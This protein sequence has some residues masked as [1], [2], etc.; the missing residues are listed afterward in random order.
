MATTAVNTT[1]NMA[2]AVGGAPSAV[3]Q[4]GQ[5]QLPAA[6]GAANTSISLSN[7]SQI[8]QQPAVRKA[9]PAIIAFL[10]V[11]VFLI[12]YSWMQDPVYR[13]VY[14]GLSESDRQAAFEALAGADFKARIDSSTGDLK[15]PDSRYHEARIFLAARGLPQEG[16][17][18][19]ISGL[20]DEASMTSSQFMEQVRYV[21]AMEQELARSITQINTIHSARVHLAS[22]KQSVFVRNRTPAKASVVVSPYPGRQVS[23]SQVEAITH[24]VSSSVPYLAAD[25]VVVVDQR[26]KLLTDANNFA[27]MQLN[28]A[29]M[30]HKQRLEETYRNRIDALLMPVV[31]MGNVRAEVDI[32][33]DYTEEESTY[34]EYDG[35][36]NGPKARSEVL[37][38]DQDAV[39]SAEGI[40]GATSNTVPA[41]AT[42]ILNGQLDGNGEDSGLRTSSSTTTRNYEMDRTVRHVKRQ[43][44]SVERISVAVVINEPVAEAGEAEGFSELELERFS[45]LVKGVV[46]FDGERGD[47]VTIVS[48]TFETPEPFQSGIAWYEN[49]QVI[50][51][52]KTLGAA[53]MFL[54]ILLS[55]VRPVIKAYLP[56]VDETL[57]GDL[58]TSSKDGELNDEEMRLIEMRD[59][60]SLEDIKAKLKPKKSTISAEMLD[61]ANTYDD[62]VALV[63]LLVAEDS[64]RVANVLKKMIRP[65]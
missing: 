57:A 63:R 44:G 10:S 13:T 50:S 27:S 4:S 7:L 2:P 60:E 19:G 64:G 1:Q 14:P 62:K 12:A 36:N 59:G 41:N 29:Q 65:L 15:V 26:G 38:L 51:G 56:A 45:D 53:I 34:E 49:G 20:S 25:D 33:V 11:A 42:A 37:S 35:N 28:S 61:T 5:A 52:I 16:T 3:S 40:P 8:M 32:Q 18:G 54:F 23:R 21:S 47:V 55:I 24:M 9:M 30:E 43:G 39:S 58:P 46:G 22:P 17:A 48:A 31:G 6:Q